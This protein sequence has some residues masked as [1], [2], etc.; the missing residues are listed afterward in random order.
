MIFPSDEQQQLLGL[1][2]QAHPGHRITLGDST[3]EIPARNGQADQPPRKLT[4]N[5]PV[6]FMTPGELKVVAE[7]QRLPNWLRWRQS[8]EPEARLRLGRLKVSLIFDDQETFA[9]VDSETRSGAPEQF[10]LPLSCIAP[11]EVAEP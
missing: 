7:Q 11:F 1:Y 6:W 2:R 9:V 8:P 10:R 3:V 4:V 5:S